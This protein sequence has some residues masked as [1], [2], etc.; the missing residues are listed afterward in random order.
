MLIFIGANENALK[1][2]GENIR[3]IRTSKGYSLRDL[4]GQVGVSAS[5]I[6]QVEIG[7]ISPSLS[8]LKDISDALNTTVGLLIGEAVPHTETL[9]VKKAD[10]RHVDH[11]GAGVN[12]SLL[13]IPDPFKQME[14]LIFEL[15]EG[16][17]SGEKSFQH[18]GQEFVLVM[19]GTLEFSLKE[20]RYQLHE[21]DS[22]YFNSS[23]PHSF[24]NSGKGEAIA[25]WVIT[26]PSF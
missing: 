5:F 4:A 2:V 12:V 24:R 22:L 3:R 25:L 26:P 19:K 17:S 21:G 6:S 1:I 15:E 23:T 14:P 16:A 7:K 18:Y 11:I 10:R 9:V 13:S 20:Q 8:K